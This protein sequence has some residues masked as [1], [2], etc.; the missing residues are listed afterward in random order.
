MPMTTKT[1]GAPVVQPDAPP[2]PNAE[3]EPSHQPEQE[4]E[5]IERAIVEEPAERAVVKRPPKRRSPSNG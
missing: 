3:P 4:P 1:T 2:V 5:A